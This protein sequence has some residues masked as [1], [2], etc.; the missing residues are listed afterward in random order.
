MSEL[1]VG[2]E[3]NFGSSSCPCTKSDVIMFL[4]GQNDEA[5]GEPEDDS[6]LFP[7][8]MCRG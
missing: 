3:P 8:I 6:P 4:W 2:E 7:I 5:V 1:V